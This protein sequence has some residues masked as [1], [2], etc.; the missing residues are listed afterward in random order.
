MSAPSVW[1]DLDFIAQPFCNHCGAAFEYEYEEGLTCADCL[2]NPP[3]YQSARSALI[4]NDKAKD[5]ILSFKHGD[6]LHA[7]ACFT[8]WLKLAGADMLARA[9]MLIPVPLHHWRL[10]KRRYNQAALIAD[11]LAKETGVPARKMILKRA[12]NTPSQGRMSRQQ[13]AQ[14]IKGAFTVPDQK[15]LYIQDKRIILIDDVFTTGATLS[16][17]TNILLKA[18]A[19]SV[20]CLS[21]ARAPAPSST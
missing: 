1:K 6:Q 4:Y 15:K 16:E 21:I 19:Q 13:R 5:L 12:R 10:V 18:G 2:E 7:A 17:C 20:E 9:D 8:P 11:A 3:L 14:N